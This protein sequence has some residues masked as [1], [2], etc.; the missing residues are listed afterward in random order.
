MLCGLD[1]SSNTLSE[2]RLAAGYLSKYV[3][4]TFGDP[5]SRVFGLHR[6]DAAQRFM[7]HGMALHGRS[8]AEVLARATDYMGAAPGTEWS[9]GSVEDWAGPPAVWAHW[10]A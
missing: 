6:Y 1:V 5:G 9:S 4:K 3:S 8:A 10:G 7:P 2:A